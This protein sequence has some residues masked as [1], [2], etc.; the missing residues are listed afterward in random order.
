MK[1][2]K[3]IISHYLSISYKLL[4]KNKVIQALFFLFEN[5]L[6]IAQIIDIYSNDFKI[7]ITNNTNIF[8]P[9]TNLIIAVKILS[10]ILNF[11]IYFSIIIILIISYFVLNILRSK[12]NTFNRVLINITELF[13]YRLFSLFIFNYLF[14]FKGI[15]LFINIIFIIPFLLI[16]TLHFYQNNLFLFFPNLIN[17]PYDKFSMLIDLHLLIVKI[18]LS[19]SGM[20]LNEKISKL[21]FILSIFILL[22]LLIYLSY[23]MIKKSFYL[24][25]NCSLNKIRYSIILSSCI[26]IILILIVDKSTIYNLFYE[27]CYFNI[28]LMCLLLVCYFY[29]PYQFCK[30]DSDDN[31]ENIYYYF[32]ILDREK[33]DYFLLEQKIEEHLSKCNF[34]NLCKKYKDFKLKNNDE[35]IDLYYIISNCDNILLNLLNNLVKGIKKMEGKVLLIILII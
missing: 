15:Y 13:F 31:I 9:L 12:E 28:L 26:M 8:S 33:N 3:R 4:I 27:I 21:G 17:Y 34:C 30:F 5:L 1:N 7:H 11:I 25:N 32:F 29:D 6:I 2:E 14:I 23:I 19:I 24:M 10:I 20:I 16:L 22:T 18:F 35:E